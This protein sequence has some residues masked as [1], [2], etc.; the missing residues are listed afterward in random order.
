[1]CK[2]QTIHIFSC[3]IP[4]LF[5]IHVWNRLKMKTFYSTVPPTHFQIILDG[6]FGIRTK[7][8]ET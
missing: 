6:H 2:L 8:E 1:M 5:K 4:R 3:A 7:Q